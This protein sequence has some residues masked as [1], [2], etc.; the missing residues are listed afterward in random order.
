MTVERQSDGIQ[1]PLRGEIRTRGD[2][3][4]STPD[5][6]PDALPLARHQHCS[7]RRPAGVKSQHQSVVTHLLF[8]LT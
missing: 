6:V 7:G 3:V 8:A 1:H 2:R 4:P 5:A